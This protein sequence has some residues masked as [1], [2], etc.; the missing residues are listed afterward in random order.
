MLKNILG[1]LL[2]ALSGA[3]PLA[4]AQSTYPARPVKIV[5]PVT[6]GGPSDLVARILGD[7]LSAALG[8]PV[9]IENRPG[10]YSL[11]VRGQPATAG[12]YAG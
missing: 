5:V 4:F 11:R 2:I 9:V 3:A 10:A 1:S 12:S 7:K 6:T 8:K